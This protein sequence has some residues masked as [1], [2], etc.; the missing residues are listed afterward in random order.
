MAGPVKHYGRWRIRWK[1]HTGRRRSAVF[2]SKREADQALLLAQADGVVAWLQVDRP[3]STLKPLVG[4][5]TSGEQTQMTARRQ[6]KVT[7]K[8]KTRYKVTNWAEYDEALRRRG[9]VTV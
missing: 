2:G 6:S 1:D 9:E 5:S 3:D 7:V 8:Y 4:G